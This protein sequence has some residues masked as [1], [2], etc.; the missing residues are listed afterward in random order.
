MQ[1]NA[2]PVVMSRLS[3]NW[4]NICAVELSTQPS[5][6]IRKCNTS[7]DRHDVLVVLYFYF[8]QHYFQ[9]LISFISDITD[10]TSGN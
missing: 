10:Q 4:N 7:A 8:Q 9:K 5:E 3:R 6:N 1:L 2:D